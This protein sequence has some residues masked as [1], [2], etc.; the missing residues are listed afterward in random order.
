MYIY[1][2]TDRQTETGTDRQTD[3]Q[4]QKQRKRQ[5]ETDRAM[6][7]SSH[8]DTSLFIAHE[9]APRHPPSC[10]VADVVADVNVSSHS[11]ASPSVAD[12][13]APPVC[14][15]ADV[16]VD[17]IYFPT[18]M[19]HHLLRMLPPHNVHLPVLSTDQEEKA[20]VAD[21]SLYR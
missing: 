19:P 11:D 18:V 14:L 15:V 8:S 20:L 3:R 1:T 7:V 13:A 9:P 12:V 6:T 5:T 2:E 17:L 10:F 21:F 16:V 4:R